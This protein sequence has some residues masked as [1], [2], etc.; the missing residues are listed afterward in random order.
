MK[1]TNPVVHFE[2]PGEDM[3]RMKSFYEKAF[4]WQM[5]QLGAEMGNYVVVHTTETDENNMVKTPGTINGGFYQ[6]TADPKSQY[7]SI[8]ISVPDIYA[9]MEQ[10]K[11][12]GGTVVGGG[13]KAGEPDDIPGV[14]MFI[15][16]L[17]SEGN[18]VS[19]LQPKQ[20]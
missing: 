16:I 2:I 15:S 7:P 5:N 6:K 12:A 9:A 3:E 20:M 13:H 8:V 17:D 11:N 19:L 14:G 10:V 4:G 18:R 1:N